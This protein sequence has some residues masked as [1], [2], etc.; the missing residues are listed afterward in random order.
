L[1][2]LLTIGCFGD[3]KYTNLFLVILMDRNLLDLLSHPGRR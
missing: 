2:A 1:T 3:Y